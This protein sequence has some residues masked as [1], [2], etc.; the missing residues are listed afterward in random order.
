MDSKEPQNADK[1]KEI[2]NEVLDEKLDQK[3]SFFNPL[4]EENE[5]LKRRTQD[6]EY[7]MD[8]LE[9][10][11]RKNNVVLYGISETENEDLMGVASELGQ[12]VEIEIKPFHID[13]V[14]RLQTRKKKCPTPIIIKFVNR[15]LRDEVQF[16]LTADKFG[17]RNDDKIFCRDHLTP[18]NQRINMEAKMLWKNYYI[19]TKKGQVYC[20]G[21][22]GKNKPFQL[23]DT[24][25][26]EALA[27]ETI[28]IEEKQRQSNEN[29]TNTVTLSLS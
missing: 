10:Y 5:T 28:E 27:E 18:K 3:M 14:H 6:L 25:D 23:L 16:K 22:I 26:I 9:W 24:S 29:E 12:A 20:K 2:L 19:Y 4:W 21:K 13:T 17:G 7:K 15:W 8:E 1:L 11:P